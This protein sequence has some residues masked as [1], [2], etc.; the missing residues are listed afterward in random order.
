MVIGGGRLDKI[1]YDKFLE[2]A[3]GPD[4]KVVVIPTAAG[5]AYFERDPKLEGLN[6]TE[7]R[8]VKRLR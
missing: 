8:R 1:F 7:F 4:A 3:G 5:D 2:F 6:K